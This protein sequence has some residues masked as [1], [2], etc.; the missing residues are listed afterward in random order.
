MPRC[1]G[2]LSLILAKLIYCG[3]RTTYI[4]Q[5]ALNILLLSRRLRGGYM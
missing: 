5:E 2:T 3:N 1:Y 4:Q